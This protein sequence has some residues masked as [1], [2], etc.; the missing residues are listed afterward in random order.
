MTIPRL[1]VTKKSKE[2]PAISLQTL[3][4]LKENLIRETQ[5]L[6]KQLQDPKQSNR[7][8]SNA[9]YSKIKSNEAT[10]IKIKLVLQR[11][12]MDIYADIFNIAEYKNRKN[13]LLQIKSTTKKAGFDVKFL[14]EEID[15]L[16]KDIDSCQY[17]INE[18][19]KNIV[20]NPEELGID[21]ADKLLYAT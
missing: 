21:V 8:E 2:Y 7:K 9:I 6:Y 5:E 1:W 14:D 4:N 19:N 20:I 3:L 11:I 15:K 12:N 16:N 18:Y 13:L 17:T 10:F